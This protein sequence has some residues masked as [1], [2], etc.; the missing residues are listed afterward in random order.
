MWLTW[1][2]S[3]PINHKVA[4]SIPG[5]G[6]CVGCGFDPSQGAF[7]KQPIDIS[8]LYQCFSPFLSPSLPLS[9]KSI[10]MSL[11]EDLKKKKMK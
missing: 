7:K 5:Q 6:T 3:C 1:L 2:E 8:L 11:C 9:L 4:V 10:S